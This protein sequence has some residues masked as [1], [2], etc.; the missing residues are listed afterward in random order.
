MISVVIPTRN[1]PAELNVVLQKIAEQ[2]LSVSE[3]IVVDSSDFATPIS[4]ESTGG[5]KLTHK[6]T[7]VKSASIQRNIG[8]ELVSDKCDFLCLLDDDVEPERDYLSTL[9]ANLSS[10]GGIGISGIALNP[11]MTHILR[12]KP[13]GLFGKLQKF[14]GLDSDQDGELLKS[15]VN[16][17]VR[18]YSGKT[19]EVEWLIGCSIWKFQEISSLRFESDFM[20]QSLCE[21]VIYSL[22]AS[23]LGKLLVDPSVHL[24]HHESDV[25]RPIGIEFWTMWV[26]NR[27]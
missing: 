17:P 21:D 6:Y 2:S 11:K 27:K 14:F 25:G 24:K 4:P 26:V 22:R 20:G 23:K 12:Q 7:K 10:L 16:I 1:R 5:F 15:G 18:S 13:K 19:Q 3:V 9:I 8:I